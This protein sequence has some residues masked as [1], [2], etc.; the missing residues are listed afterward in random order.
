MDNNEIQKQWKTKY[1]WIF[2]TSKAQRQ[3]HA[4][5]RQEGNSV[6]RFSAWLFPP[7]NYE[8]AAMPS[9]RLWT[10]VTSW[11]DPVWKIPCSTHLNITFDI[12][13]S[14]GIRKSIRRRKA[15][16]EVEAVGNFKLLH[17]YL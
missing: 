1:H 17:Q 4:V 11:P 3:V 12:P 14:S 13:V 15:L 8:I 6:F 2:S 10:A 9:G 7:L 5:S 16:K